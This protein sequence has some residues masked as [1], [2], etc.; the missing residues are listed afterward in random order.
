[1]VLSVLQTIQKN[2]LEELTLGEAGKT[3]SI[4]FIVNKLPTFPLVKDAE[5][6]QALCIGGRVS[7]V[8]LVRNRG[9]SIEIIKQ[10]TFDQPPFKTKQDFIDAIASYI[11]P[12][13]EVLAINFALF[14]QKDQVV[15]LESGN[16]DKFPQT[17][18][19]KMID[20]HSAFPGRQLFEK[21]TAG[22]YLFQ[23]FNIEPRLSSTKELDEVSLRGDLKAS[24]LAQSLLA[25]SAKLVC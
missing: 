13:I 5:V 12:K 2:F 4:S 15:N 8:A 7:K 10:E 14:R 18:E 9:G 20:K 17:N 16:F 24:R 1:M 19:G 23:H 6:F 3:S 25:R 21:E 11:D 22:S